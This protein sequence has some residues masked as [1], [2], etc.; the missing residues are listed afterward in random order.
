[1]EPSPPHPSEATGLHMVHNL[2]KRGLDE[3]SVALSI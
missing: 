3:H 1:M 2:A